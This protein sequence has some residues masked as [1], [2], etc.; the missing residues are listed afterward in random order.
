L[1]LQ[2]AATGWMVRGFRCDPTWTVERLTLALPTVV[3]DELI[4]PLCVAALNTPSRDAS[5][6]VFLRVLRDALFSGPGSSDLLIPRRPLADLLPEPATQWLT[7]QG[8]TCLLGHRVSSLDGDG[9]VNDRAFD[10][11]VLA[12]T[13]REAA[14]L[15]NAMAPDW[16]AATAGF[17][18]E[19]IITG[20]IRVPGG[21]LA[22]PMLSVREGPQA[23]AQ[24]AFDHGPLSGDPGLLALVV[25]GAAPWVVQG[26]TATRDAL[27]GQARAITHMATDA[28]PNHTAVMLQQVCEKRATFRCTPG[29][30]RPSAVISERIRAAGD[31]IEGP[32]P[33][34]LEGAVRSGQTSVDDL[35][36]LSMPR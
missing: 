3:R 4:D 6:Q 36:D 30:V 1:A 14:R 24:F 18:Y 29:L 22:A 2:F 15:T 8:A 20:Y 5:A 17:R 11:V 13:A 25:S 27:V 19:P 16:S 33:A 32:Y 12:C 21:Q 10:R 23:P 7:R 31:Y 35:P 26:T 9:H 34:T 28:G